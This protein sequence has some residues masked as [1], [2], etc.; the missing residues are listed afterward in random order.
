M[1]N[2]NEDGWGEYS[3]LVLKELEV[4]AAGIKELN[5]SI[6]EMKREITEIRAREDKVHELVKWKERIDEVTS[7][8]Q[9]KELTD[10]VE[11]LKSFKI[12]A[13]T[14]FSVVQFT[15]AVTVFIMNFM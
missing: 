2:N 9:L 13:I 11:S 12:Q 8:S 1:P 3:R 4:L 7:A 6:N 10:S 14:I 15:M 5:D